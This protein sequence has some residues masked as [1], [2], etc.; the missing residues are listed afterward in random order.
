MH[1]VSRWILSF[2]IIFYPIE[3]AVGFSDPNTV[4]LPIILGNNPSFSQPIINVPFINVTDVVSQKITE[5][6]IFWFGKVSPNDSYADVRVGYNNTEL[7]FHVAVFDRLLWYDPSPATADLTQWDAVA[8]TLQLDASGS[9]KP[10][11]SS[12]Q[13]LAGMHWWESDGLYQKSY[14]GDGAAWIPQ[15]VPFTTQSGWRGDKPNNATD[16]RGWTMDFH[17]PFASLGLAAKPSENTVWK[18]GIILY[19]RNNPG[20]QA[21]PAK[22]WPDANNP[23]NPATWGQLRFSIPVYQSPVLVNNQTTTIRQGLNGATVPDGAVGGGTIC[24]DGLDYFSQWGDANYHQYTYMNIQNQID[25]ADW[26]CYSKYYVRFP[27][28][29]I[30]PGKGIRS[31]R[32]LLHQFGGSEPSLAFPSLIQVMTTGHDWDEK[33]L[34]WNNTPL[35]L[36]NISQTWV[37]VLTGPLVWPG[38][39]YSWDVSRA[40]S[41]AYQSGD[42][43]SLVLYSADYAYHSG[44]YFT[45]S[46]AEEWDKAGRPAL[47]VEWGEYAPTPN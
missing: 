3:T 13:F 19:N 4:Y 35:A 14:K 6:G 42:P 47:L 9:V 15:P 12:Y 21:V 25:V 33:T 11:T 34:S 5:M 36:E 7:D 30:P 41:Q 28:G 16:D 40:V 29:Q 43:L 27:L 32:L 26:P 1:W 18:L 17:I 39:E 10:T 38:V 8:I 45:T 44:K 46:E 20:S 37:Q 23:N 24:G 2:L 22:Y 31:A